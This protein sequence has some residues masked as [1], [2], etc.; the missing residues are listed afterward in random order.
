M[1]IVLQK[2]KVEVL[3]ASRIDLQISTGKDGPALEIASP[4]IS[5]ATVCNSLELLSV[6]NL[7]LIA[8]DFSLQI[9]R[10]IQHD[11]P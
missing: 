11:T 5:K 9:E 8:V 1:N 10:S 4:S 6:G 3:Y 7:I 2:K